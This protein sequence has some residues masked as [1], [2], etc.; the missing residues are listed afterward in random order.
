MKLLNITGGS[1][2]FIQIAAALYV[3][4][5]EGYRFTDLSVI[6]ASA[7]AAIPYVFGMWDEMFNEGTNLNMDKIF[8]VTPTNSRGNLTFIA[9]LRATLSFFTNINSF[10]VQDIKPILKKYITEELFE[11][12][13]VSNKPNIHVVAYEPTY[14]RIY[15][16]NLKDCANVEE[17]Y[18]LIM[19]SSAIQTYT[20]HITYHDGVR[21]VDLVDGGMW[22]AGAGGYLME[23]GYFKNVESVVSIYSWELGTNLEQS[24][25]WKKNIMQNIARTSMGFKNANMWY[26]PRHEY[27]YCTHQDNNIPIMQIFTPNVL[28][29]SD[30]Y[31]VENLTE[32]KDKT[33]ASVKLQIEKYR[34]SR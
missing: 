19:G 9:L 23:S 8:K 34:Q 29:I 20:Q 15:V 26:A 16:K 25:N 13:K 4:H 28:D 2:K 17:C 5:Q 24:S 11:K 22:V 3:L 21:E 33:L 12:Y 1:T 7:I 18:S 27:W 31:D 32:A 30:L 10:G 14:N 6:S